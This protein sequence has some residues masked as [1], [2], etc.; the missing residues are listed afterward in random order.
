MY[1]LNPDKNCF[2]MFFQLYV[3]LQTTPTYNNLSKVNADQASNCTLSECLREC[4]SVWSTQTLRT[5]WDTDK[6]SR[7][8]GCCEGWIQSLWNSKNHGNV[9]N[10]T[11]FGL[12][13]HWPKTYLTL[14][15]YTT[16]KS[17]LKKDLFLLVSKIQYMFEEVKHSSSKLETFAY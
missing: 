13:R 7:W 4:W 10:P 3:N 11:P 15:S 6:V 1:S 5:S 17:V 16:N 12:L 9:H 2:Y 8:W 14:K